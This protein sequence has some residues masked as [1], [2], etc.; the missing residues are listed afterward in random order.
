MTINL[1]IINYK[2]QAT[3]A[4]FSSLIATIE[5]FN[6]IT[7]V[8]VVKNMQLTEA[9]YKM[10]CEMGACNNTATHTIKL[11]RVGVR[12]Q[13]HVCKDCLLELAQLVTSEMTPKSIE[14]LKPS[15]VTKQEV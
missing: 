11:S 6:F 9:K 13:I 3:T 14:T 1:K 4:I 12:S 8:V 15:K 10:K 2:E 7:K 5:K